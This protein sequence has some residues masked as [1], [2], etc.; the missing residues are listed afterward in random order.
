M[1]RCIN[2]VLIIFNEL[3]RM[4]LNFEQGNKERFL[5]LLNTPHGF[6]YF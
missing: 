6:K 5:V 1:H 2:D 3:V 4:I